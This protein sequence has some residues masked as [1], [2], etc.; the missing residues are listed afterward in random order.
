MSL[1]VDLDFLSSAFKAVTRTDYID[2]VPKQKA[3]DY[4]SSFDLD[5]LH[6][7]SLQWSKVS[8]DVSPPP[9]PRAPLSPPVSNVKAP[10]ASSAA[11]PPVTKSGDSAPSGVYTGPVTR[12]RK[13]KRMGEIN[14]LYRHK[15][16]KINVD[17]DDHSVLDV[18]LKIQEEE[19]LT[20]EQLGGLIFSGSVL[21]DGKKLGDC[22]VQIGSSLHLVLKRR[23]M[24]LTKDDGVVFVKTLTGKTIDIRVNCQDS[25]ENVKA[26]IQDKVGIPPDQQRL[27]FAGKQLEDGRTLGDYNIHS[28]ST[29]HLV[30]RLRGGG[31]GCFAMDEAILDQKYNYDFSKMSD[32]G[33]RFFRGGRAYRRPYGWNRIALNVKDKYDDAEW[34][35]GIQSVIR[36]DG[37]MNEW[38]VTYHGTKDTFAKDIAAGGYDLAKGERFK[39]GRGIYS[40][41]DPDIAEDYATTFEFK[42]Q[43]YKVLLQNRVNM[44]DTDVVAVTHGDDEGEYFVTANEES[45]RP[46]G[47]L[48]KKV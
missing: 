20:P 6:A 3:P 22:N 38:P 26:K 36:T 47:M 7:R 44:E 29:F 39:F 5:T 2:I 1:S 25:I 28:E 27:I 45:I 42:G 23:I 21:D 8:R 32:D 40:T 31:G 33:E 34:I 30:L 37:V 43:K 4:A 46:Y 17:I 15:T 10:S 12:S 24:P 48:F 19:G 13:R 11:S 14:V 16:L 35:G 9:T 18:K 41:P